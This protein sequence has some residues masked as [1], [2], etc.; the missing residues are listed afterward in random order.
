MIIYFVVVLVLYM[1]AMI[2]I[3][4]FA[5]NRVKSVADLHVGGMNVGGVFVALSFFTT[6]FS[7]VVFIGATAL[8]W[9]YGL[10]VVWK[11]VFV[12]LIGTALAFILL[13]PRIACLSR[14]LGFIT[15]S[16]F[17]EKRYGSR[18]AGLVTSV[19]MFVGLLIYNVSAL[20]GTARAVEV[21]ASIDYLYALLL[22]GIVTAIYT[23]VG[24]YIAQMW[25]QVV[26][27]IFMIFMAI[28]ICVVSLLRVGGLDTLSTQLRAI[29]PSLAGWPY[30]DALPL[31]TLYLSL[32]FLGWGNPALLLRFVSVR[33]R[34][35]LGTA[36]VIATA[37]S[38]VFTLSLDL[39][40]ATSRIIVGNNVAPDYSFVYLVQNIMP[41]GFDAL[42]VVAVLSASMSTISAILGV[43]TQNIRDFIKS[44]VSLDHGKE[45]AL[46]RIATIAVAVSSIAL[47]TKPP[48]MII[49]LFGVTTSILAGVLIGPIIYG[50]YSK[51]VSPIAIIVT[52]IVSFALAIGVS[53]YGQFK[54]PWTYYSFIPTILTSITLPPIITIFTEV[55]HPK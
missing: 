17:V 15:I 27:A 37:I 7:S 9:K 19:V 8:G 54:F 51:R 21:V 5:M 1:L 35:S 28:A 30:K 47:A 25:T 10:P 18:L 24:G 13:G 4:F 16:E 52:M 20:I 40:S 26:Q 33:N 11:D 46:Y 44:F 41:K 55:K 34:I 32:G 45:I 14:R 22:T 42:F 31:F 50:L 12:V 53:A 49:V 48:E 6:Y 43:M 2:L 38:A 29:D 3:G 36:T 23:A 39:A